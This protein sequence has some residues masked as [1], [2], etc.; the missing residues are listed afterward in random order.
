MI[1]REHGC[2]ATIYHLTTSAQQLMQK[3]GGTNVHNV[4]ELATIGTRCGGDS[5]TIQII[6]D[7]SVQFEG[8]R[9][10]KQKQNEI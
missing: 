8:M 3:C 9:V 4:D 2:Y 1:Q 10:R 6:I 5:S 7:Y